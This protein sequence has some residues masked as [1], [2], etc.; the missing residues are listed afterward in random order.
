[1]SQT[2]PA[3]V[4]LLADVVHFKE[5]YGGYNGTCGET[6]LT[7]ALICALKLGS[8]NESH[9]AAVALMLSVTSAMRAAGIADANGATTLYDLAQEAKKQGASIATEWDYAEPFPHDWH[10]LLLQ[11]AGLKPIVLQVGKAFNLVGQDNTG[12][13]EAGVDY[14]F[15][16]VVGKC[17][18]GYIVMD[19]DNNL[20]EQELAIYSY[21]TLEAADICGLLMLDVVGSPAPA[22][23]PAPAPAPAPAPTPAPAPA[24]AETDAQKM[25]ALFG[26]TSVW[27]GNEALNWTIADFTN[28]AKSIKALG[29]DSMTVKRADGTSKWYAS[30]TQIQSE[31]SAVEAEGLHY[32]PF[33]YCY[34]PKFG[35]SQIEGECA[36]L[37]ELAGVANVVQADMETEWNGNVA[38]A[39]LF[40][41]IMKPMTQPLSVTIVAD[42]TVQNWNGVLAALAPVVNS[43]VP[44]YY[45]T[46][47]SQQSLPSEATVVQPGVDICQRRRGFG[48]PADSMNQ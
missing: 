23:V 6:A 44:Q 14:H 24:P 26:N 31:K 4:T 9:D 40:A 21:A 41:S 43:W 17:A 1:M 32:I 47:L 30:I 22:P 15:I 25:Q 46:W 11:N 37:K 33:I 18:D 45:D 7:A 20:V 38:A 28:A 35:N 8:D 16:C 29:F 48:S 13:A 39:Q 3:P 10:D 34:G 42:P 36:I 19:G 27:V 12:H 5:F 2:F